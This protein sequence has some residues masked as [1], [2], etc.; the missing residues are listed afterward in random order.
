VAP[1]MNIPACSWVVALAIAALLVPTAALSVSA[2]ELEND[3][4]VSYVEG[5]DSFEMVSE[6][7]GFKVN[8]QFSISFDE[9]SITATYTA[10]PATTAIRDWQLELTLERVIGFKDNGN[11]ILDSGDT[12]VWTEDVEDMTFAVISDFAPLPDGGNL[13]T[14]TAVSEGGMLTLEFAF[15]TSPALVGDVPISPTDVKLSIRLDLTDSE[16]TFDKVAL[17]ISAEVDYLSTLAYEGEDDHQELN[18]THDSMGGFFSWSSNATVD[19]FSVPV[20]VSWSENDLALT[21]PA[22]DLIVHDPVIGVRSVAAL[23]GIGQVSEIIGNPAVFIAGL[24]FASALVLGTV[25]VRKRNKD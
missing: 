10:D 15:T 1:R 13:T 25:I 19:G 5:P 23:S 14:V 11:G 12:I 4:E 7:S 2:D 17:V 18:L 9:G 20:G 6:S 22:G 8:D 3:R 21:Y 24:A 16:G